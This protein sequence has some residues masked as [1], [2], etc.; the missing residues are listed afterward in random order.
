MPRH[1]TQLELAVR[2]RLHAAGLRFTVNRRDLPGRPDVVLSRARLAVFVDGC[3]WHAC[4]EHAVWPKNNAGWWKAKLTANVERDRRKDT[5]LQSLGWTV[6]H[7][8]EHDPLDV[9]C[10]TVID[11]WKLRTGRA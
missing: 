10:Q 11:V 4:P 2:R 6:L 1:S 8:W 9:I 3:F 5:E 7:F